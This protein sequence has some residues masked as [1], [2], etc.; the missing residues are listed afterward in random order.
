LTGH[1]NIQLEVGAGAVLTNAPAS[2]LAIIKKNLTFE[3]PRYRDAKKYSRWIGK[4]LKPT[5]SFYQQQENSLIFP[6]GFANNAIRL[7]RDILHITPDIIDKRRLLTKVMFKFSVPLRPYQEEAC[8]AILKRDFGVL[9]AGTGSGK[10]VMALSVISQR[11]QPALILVHTKELLYQWA[12]RVKQ[13]MEEEPA[14]IGAGNF[15]IGPLTIA[16]VNSAR[17]RLP[18][19]K[20]HFGMV[21]VDE[22]HRVPATLFTD[23]VTTFDA[24]YSLGLSATAFRRD[25]LDKLIYYYLGECVHRIDNRKLQENGAILKPCYIQRPTLFHYRYMGNYQNLLKK[26]ISDHQRNTLIVNDII[27]TIKKKTG[28]ILVVSDR[29]AHCQNLAALLKDKGVSPIVLTGRIPAMQRQEFIKKLQEGKVEVVIATIQLIGEGFDCPGLD[30][31]FLTTPI[32]FSGR[33][34]QV[35]GR[36]LRPA[37]DKKAMVYDYIDQVNVLKKSALAREKLFFNA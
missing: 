31:L 18:D 24:R 2:L 30:T 9:E 28:T 32:K 11:Q 6:R 25:G 13:F 19:L 1:Q 16:I 20:P 29:V 34:L 10:T 12:E 3:N 26:L 23:V 22:C 21:C 27:D 15:S 7:C 17:R 33:L 36:I 37:N 5:L 8:Q 14:L 4:N 35:V